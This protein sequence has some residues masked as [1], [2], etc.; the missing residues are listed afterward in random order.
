[1]RDEAYIPPL[2]CA[3]AAEM[4]EPS[5]KMSAISWLFAGPPPSEVALV[6]CCEWLRCGSPNSNPNPDPL[7]GRRFQPPPLTLAED[8]YGPSCP[9]VESTSVRGVSGGDRLDRCERRNAAR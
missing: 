5:L 6:L 1:M 8:V 4:T 9:V 2:C 3:D 7:V